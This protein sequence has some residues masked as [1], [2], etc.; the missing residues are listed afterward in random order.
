MQNPNAIVMCVQ[1]MYYNMYTC[2]V[3]MKSLTEAYT[4]APVCFNIIS[5]TH[6][7]A[8]AFIKNYV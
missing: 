1:G 2:I 4:I 8:I 6:A 7:I 3:I 5:Y